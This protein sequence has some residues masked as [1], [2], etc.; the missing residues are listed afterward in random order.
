M[1]SGSHYVEFTLERYQQGR[2]VLGLAKETF[3]PS[4]GGWASATSVGVKIKD[5][6]LENEDSCLEK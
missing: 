5:P 6:P 3:D 2:M 4:G 1:T